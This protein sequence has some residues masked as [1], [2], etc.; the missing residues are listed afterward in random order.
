MTEKDLMKAADLLQKDNN[1]LIASHLNPDGD[2]VGSALALTL[3]LKGL[4][5]KVSLT[6]IEPVPSKYLFL[7]QT[8]LVKE[9]KEVEGDHFNLFVVLDCSD[10]K[11]LEPLSDYLSKKDQLL[12][13]DHHVTNQYFGFY[14]YVNPQA[15]SVGEIIF[16]LLKLMKIEINYEIALCL[17]VAIS[18]DT[19]S[20]KFSN[21]TPRTHRIVAEL[22]ELGVDPAEVNR[23]VYE[24]VSKGGVML[25]R[26]ALKTL[27]F[28]C[29]DKIAYLTITRKIME[30]AGAREEDTEGIINY[31]R[32]IRGV[33]VGILFREISKGKTRVAFRSHDVDVS[34]LAAIYEGG[35]HPRAAGC[36]VDKDLATVRRVVLKQARLFINDLKNK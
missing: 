33:E 35:G 26:E 15:S 19:G 29:Q 17:Y 14:N 3:A 34:K 6:T 27:E 11:R 16:E 28:D 7:P 1:I 10:L 13:I 32:N 9:W 4:D 36:Q 2:S 21:T 22:I 25:I 18:T 30:K 8:E 5:K 12:N 24:N 20:F 31:A 23:N